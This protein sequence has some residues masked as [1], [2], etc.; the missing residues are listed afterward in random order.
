MEGAFSLPTRIAACRRLRTH[1]RCQLTGAAHVLTAL[2]PPPA[3]CYRCCSTNTIGAVARIRNA[4]AYAT[5]KFF[6]VRGF[7]AVL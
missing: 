5:H 1:L 4:L 7:T 3:P 6:Q 2:P